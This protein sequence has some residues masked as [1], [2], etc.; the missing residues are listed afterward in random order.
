MAAVPPLMALANG[1]AALN[2]GQTH[3]RGV[4]NADSILVGTSTAIADDP[5][6][7][8]RRPDGS[9]FEDQP[10]R[11]VLGESA[12]PNDFAPL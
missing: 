5:E 4:Q 1:L 6:L 8:A 11:I 10:I 2:Q 9:Y 7:T 3:I 12:I